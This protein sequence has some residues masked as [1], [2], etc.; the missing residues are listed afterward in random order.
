MS[1]AGAT[2]L[3]LSILFFTFNDFLCEI[4]AGGAR[5][6]NRIPAPLRMDSSVI[7]RGALSSLTLIA[8]GINEGKRSL[9]H[10][11][12]F[13]HL[14]AE[15]GEIFFLTQPNGEERAQLIN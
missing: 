7:A 2:N 1:A 12:I 8:I 5:H 15:A 3:I 4:I 13:L 6:T 9:T 11:L 10:T 14:E